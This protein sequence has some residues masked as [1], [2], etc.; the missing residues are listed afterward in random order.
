MLF[1]DTHH[2][3]CPIDL[4]RKRM[5]S[6]ITI[7]H[8]SLAPSCPDL[9]E[10][11]MAA[12][13]PMVVWSFDLSTFM[14]QFL[15]SWTNGTSQ[16]SYAL[17]FDKSGQEHFLDGN[18]SLA[19]EMFVFESTFSVYNCSDPALV[20]K[21]AATTDIRDIIMIATTQCVVNM[22]QAVSQLRLPST[23]FRWLLYP[24][25]APPGPN[26]QLCAGLESFCDQV[27]PLVL[28]ERGK[29]Q[30]RPVDLETKLLNFA[31]HSLD[32]FNEAISTQSNPSNCSLTCSEDCYRCQKLFQERLNQIKGQ[33][34]EMFPDVSEAERRGITFDIY[35]LTSNGNVQIGNWSAARGLSLRDRA[36]PNNF[37]DTKL[38]VVVVVEPP[39]VFKNDEDPANVFY[40][41]YSVDVLEEIAKKVGF[42]YELV[43]CSPGS[44][45]TLQDGQWTGCIGNVVRGV[46][47][48]EAFPF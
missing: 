15:V 24:T 18:N 7:K 32:I 3:A 47:R 43:E 39:F 34:Y 27:K 36:Y 12:T 29:P 4:F 40:Y 19:G 33:T 23:R 14:S 22:T 11:I 21:T 17:L 45:G 2:Q 28:V 37:T 46:R 1:L 35:R 42:E 20:V 6:Y 10:I 44:Y 41:G 13:F 38:T 8:F 25:D 31:E 48:Y 5:L 26:L 16:A 30:N 9:S